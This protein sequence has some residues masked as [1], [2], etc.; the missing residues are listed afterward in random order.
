MEATTTQPREEKGQLR[1]STQ[2]DEHDGPS[3]SSQPDK[4]VFLIFEAELQKSSLN[5]AQRS[6]DDSVFDKSHEHL[7]SLPDHA[8]C[9]VSQLY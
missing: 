3:L 5:V 9:F 2:R 1:F 8:F 6:V 4:R 7:E